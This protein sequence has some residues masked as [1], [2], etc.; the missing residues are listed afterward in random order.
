V[1][2]RTRNLF[3]L[4]LVAV[5]AVTG[6]AALIFGGGGGPIGPGGSGGSGGSGQ[7]GPPGTTAVVGAIVAVDARGLGDV[8]GFTLRRVGGQLIDFDLARLEN[9]VE[10]PP[11]HLA[12]HQATA[13]PVRVWYLDEGGVRYAIRLEDA[14]T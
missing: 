11:G 10:F 1:D 14:G 5:I 3:A 8:R 9:G 4:A 6:G 13:A 12:E 2:R 7:V